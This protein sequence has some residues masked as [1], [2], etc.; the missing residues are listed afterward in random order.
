MDR[1]IFWY[2][3]EGSKRYRV[4]YADVSI[5]DADQPPQVSGAERLRQTSKGAKPTEK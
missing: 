5:K 4:I 3:P 2:R 1:A